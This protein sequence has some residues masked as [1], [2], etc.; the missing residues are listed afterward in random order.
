MADHHEHGLRDSSFSSGHFHTHYRRDSRHRELISDKVATT[1]NSADGS[2]HLRSKNRKRFPESLHFTPSSFRLRSGTASTRSSISSANIPDS[3]TTYSLSTLASPISTSYTSDISELFAAHVID[4]SRPA[5]KIL[6]RHK[7]STGTC[8]TYVNDEDDGH[9]IAGY[10]DLSSKIRDIRG[11]S[12]ESEVGDDNGNDTLPVRLVDL[13]YFVLGS[14]RG[15]NTYFYSPSTESPPI[16]EEEGLTP[17]HSRYWQQPPSGETATASKWE[18]SSTASDDFSS[19]EA[20]TILD[21]AL[22]VVYGVDLQETS[23]S[24]PG[25]RQ[26]VSKFV[27]DVGRHI[28]HAPSD[29]QPAQVMSSSSSSSTPSQGGAGG[30]IQGGGKRKKQT[31]GE[32]DEGEFSDGEGSGLLPLKRCRPNPKEDENLRLS[33]PFRKRNPQRFNVRDHHSCAMTYF[34]KFAELR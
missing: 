5:G 22:Q 34:P 8:S 30:G 1:P 27:G 21:F 13:K 16:K 15:F 24:I 19:D 31:R 20:D 28:W 26:L 14:T 33:C 29:A 32:E 9:M 10:P 17:G 7:P 2:G 18:S 25:L 6:H 12:N 4:I 3:A 11:D 23:H